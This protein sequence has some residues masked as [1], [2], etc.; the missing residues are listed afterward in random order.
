MLKKLVNI[1][2]FLVSPRA[3]R[4]LVRILYLFFKER[5]STF[6]RASI[7]NRN[8]AL[9]SA[10]DDVF[11]EFCLFLAKSDAPDDFLVN[12]VPLDVVGVVLPVGVL[13]LCRSKAKKK[14]KQNELI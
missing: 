8:G 13:S 11:V 3:Y 12:F 4:I 6:H 1:F 5:A 9:K 14:D 7:Y 2:F 10:G